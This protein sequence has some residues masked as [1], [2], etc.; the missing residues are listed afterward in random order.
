MLALPALKTLNA[1]KRTFL[2]VGHR[3]AD[4]ILLTQDDGLLDG[5]S[6]RPGSEIKGGFSSDGKP[7]V[8][9]LPSGKIQTTLEMMQ[10][11]RTLIDDL[12]LYNLFKVLEENP[13]MSAT[14]VVELANQKG[15]LMAPTMGRQ[16][17][18]YL[19]SMVT[20][21]LDVA[22]SQR[23]LPPMPP[24]LREAG[25]EYDVVYTTPL[26]RQM[27]MQEVAGSMRTVEMVKELVAVSGDPS[28]L[29][30]IAFNR[31]VPGVADVNAVPA[32]FMAT[33]AE[34]V[35]KAKA[36]AQQQAIE[37]K[38]KMA[39]AA[40]SMMASQAKAQQG[41]AAQPPGTFAPINLQPQGPAP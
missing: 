31:M 32:S 12:S 6:L 16:Q 14:A 38:I 33:K 19:G 22:M 15:I 24:A 18:E 20:R 36:R 41:G 13:N 8:G 37:Q 17:S 35:A 1:Q 34:Q 11:E 21:E 5:V 4:P 10:E 2:K 3:D 23:L 28:L 25:G 39:P 9:V 40:A 26:S 30:P 7:L 27:R 29:D